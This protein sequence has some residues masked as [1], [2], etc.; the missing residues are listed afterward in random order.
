MAQT[1]ILVAENTSHVAT[2]EISAA[3]KGQ[4]TL[5]KIGSDL[6]LRQLHM[7]S[8]SG[9]AWSTECQE[10]VD[11]GGVAFFPAAHRENWGFPWPGAIL[12]LGHLVVA[13]TVHCHSQFCGTT[14]TPEGHG[15]AMEAS[16]HL[17]PQ[18]V[19]GGTWECCSLGSAEVWNT[20][21]TASKFWRGKNSFR[22]RDTWGWG[23][24]ERKKR[25]QGED[26]DIG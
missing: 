22:G 13:Q 17:L 12:V 4:L 23:T 16:V 21:G 19:M 2:C 14:N 8:C 5:S 1:V 7:A 10:R 9:R 18:R 24:G 6:V 11:Q 20:S 3:S 15:L 26:R 25:K